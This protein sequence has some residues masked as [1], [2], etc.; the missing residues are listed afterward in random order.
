ARQRRV[1]REALAAP[2]RDGARRAEPRRSRA[3][4]HARDRPRRVAAGGR[5]RHRG[6]PPPE[7]PRRDRDRRL[8]SW[9]ARARLILLGGV[10]PELDLGICGALLA[11]APA[12]E[13]AVVVSRLRGSGVALGR[14]QPGA[15]ALRRWTGGRTTR[16]GDGIA[17]LAAVAPGPQA[18]LDER[19]RLS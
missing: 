14:W 18:W 13:G 5:Q 16:F 10:E 11:E 19:A 2:R 3:G 15:G 9:L 7:P 6:G 17:T 8:R 12:A 1:Q 4:A